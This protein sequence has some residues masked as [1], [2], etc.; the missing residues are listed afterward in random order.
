MDV[1]TQEIIE[2]HWLETSA[3]SIIAPSKIGQTSF[4]YHPKKTC[5]VHRA[6]Y[7]IGS[8][9]TKTMAAKV[10]VCD[11][12]LEAVFIEKAYPI[13]YRQ[14]LFSSDISEFSDE[15]KT[16]GLQILRS[17]KTNIEGSYQNSAPPTAEFQH[18][19][20]ATAAFRKANNGGSYAQELSAKL[21]IPIKVISQEEEGKL[22]YYSALSQMNEVNKQSPP[23][24]WDIGG[25]SM[26]LTFKN[27]AN[28][29]YVMGGELASQTFQD[30]VGK[31]IK[32]Q[33][34]SPHPMSE[35]QVQAALALAKEHL[36]FDE[37]VFNLIQ[38]KIQQGSPIVAVGSVHNHVIQPLCNLATHSEATFYTLDDLKQAIALLTNKTDKDILELMSLPDERLVHNQLTNLILVYALMDK[39]HINKVQTVQASNVQGLLLKG[40]LTNVRLTKHSSHPSLMYLLSQLS[41]Y[42]RT[43]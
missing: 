21:E 5:I 30:L 31:S 29:F 28:D 20:I 10:N 16:K 26:K 24:V 27:E 42:N 40:C 43:L 23:I 22:A 6:A 38:E 34:G 12:T 4:S 3:V 1:L 33:S 2:T 32:G 13:L 15:I 37:A 8:N 11:M 14:D 17:A 19:G 35:S 36:V 41:Q 39:M 18:C 25:G 7:D 9:A